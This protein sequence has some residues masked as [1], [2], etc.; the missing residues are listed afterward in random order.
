MTGTEFKRLQDQINKEYFELMKFK[1]SF[2]VIV[3]SKHYQA[4]QRR[5]EDNIKS[6]SKELRA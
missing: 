1:G 3:S 2:P 5:I 4:E 6:L